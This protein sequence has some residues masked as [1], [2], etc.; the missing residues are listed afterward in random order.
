MSKT[1]TRPTFLPPMWVLSL[2]G[3]CLLLWLTYALKE[4][5]VLL[6]VGYCL[7]YAIEP[8]IS[9][10]EKRFAISRSRGILL[11]A[12][13]A[14]IILCVL[15]ITAIPPLLREGQSLIENLPEYTETVRDKVQPLLA[16][17][18]DDTESPLYDLVQS[19]FSLPDFDR[20]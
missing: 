15:L 2:I 4:I 6:V 7:S 5:V 1:T 12:V 9:F 11:V 13:L 3:T 19:R 10:F 8:I 17:I 18:I 16:E 14:L 20:R